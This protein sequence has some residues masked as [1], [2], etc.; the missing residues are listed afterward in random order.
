MVS[1][2]LLLEDQSILEA[3]ND[4][5]TWTH[6]NTLDSCP[7]QQTYQT[8]AQ[9]ALRTCF[10]FDFLIK[11]PLSTWCGVGEIQDPEKKYKKLQ[12]KAFEIKKI[13]EKSRVV[14]LQQ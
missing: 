8:L 6:K 5:Q 4:Q 12:P 1:K 9:I 10:N 11:T 14:P 3:R 2:E 13:H 7:Y